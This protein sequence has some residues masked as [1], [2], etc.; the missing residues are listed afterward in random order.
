MRSTAWRNFKSVPLNQT[1]TSKHKK[2]GSPFQSYR[3]FTRTVRP[4]SV[5]ASVI[6]CGPRHQPG[7]RLS[8]WQQ[9]IVLHGRPSWS[10]RGGVELL[11]PCGTSS[12]GNLVLPR[13]FLQPKR[14]DANRLTRSTG[15]FR[16]LLHGRDHA[17]ILFGFRRGELDQI[18]GAA[19]R[20]FLRSSRSR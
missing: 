14:R 20:H 4:E 3:P 18:R 2:S 19:R 6:L 16:K 17:V 7:K 1:A 11:Y 8:T 12:I 10:L 5:T 15:S 9:H 13:T